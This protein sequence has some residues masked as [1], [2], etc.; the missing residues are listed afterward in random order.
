MSGGRKGLTSSTTGMEWMVVTLVVLATI[1]VAS[2][3]FAVLLAGKLTGHAMEVRFG[4]TLRAVTGHP[5]NPVAAYPATA[6]DPPSAWLVWVLFGVGMLVVGVVAMV[7]WSRMSRRQRREGTADVG[8]LKRTLGTEAVRQRAARDRPSLAGVKNPDHRAAAVHLGRDLGSGIELWA[9]H[10]DSFFVVGP[11]RSG[12]TVSLCVPLV[13]DAPG[14]VVASS[15]KADL[16]MAAGIARRGH[17]AVLVFDPEDISGWPDRLRWSPVTGCENPATAIRRADAVVAAKPMSSGSGNTG[18]FTEAAGTVLRC[19]LHAAALDGRT[20]SDVV[21]WVSD[22]EDLEPLDI[23]RGHADA[24]TQWAEDLR[25]Y[26][27]GAADETTASLKMT[28]ALVLKSLANPHVLEMCSPPRDQEFDVEAFIR[29]GGT[30][31]VINSGDVSGS[32]APLCT[33]LVDDIV[34]TGKRLSQGAASGRLDPPLRV[35]LD[36][37]A[38]GCPLPGLPSYLADSGGR[39]ITTVACVQTF[40]QARAR[41]G[42]EEAGQ[43]FGAST[44]K[45]V[46]GGVPEADDLEQLSRLTGERDVPT[47]SSSRGGKG[48]NVTISRSTRR[49]RVFTPTEIRQ[50]P[51]G[52]ALLLYRTLPPVMVGLRAWM[53]RADADDLHR[54]SREAR[55]LTG[56]TP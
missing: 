23:L 50:L 19:L 6:G 46:L 49:E 15:T 55:E 52:Q 36:E 51:P 41:W 42:K 45:L 4:D 25:T 37:A 33:A 13:L 24:V 56:R 22:F 35:V 7:V 17:G 2:Y 43:I 38:T 40:A 3:H 47:Y 14:A 28:L 34:Q 20:M 30:I 29:A 9:S 21:R 53:N 10:E 48:G 26:T 11:P 8:R 31:F 44:V 12:K 54:A 5:A 16:L 18:F 1:P 32:T 39:G 27:R